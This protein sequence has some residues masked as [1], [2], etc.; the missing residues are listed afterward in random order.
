M[1]RK[2]NWTLKRQLLG[3]RVI[4]SITNC[5]L[6]SGK[7]KNEHAQLHYNCRALGVHRV[8]AHIYMG[9]DINSP[10]QVLHKASCPNRHC[11]NPEHL[12]IGTQSQNIRDT[13][14]ARTHKESRKTSC[15]RGHR[16]IDGNWYWY[17][18]RGFRKRICHECNKIK[19]KEWRDKHNKTGDTENGRHNSDAI[20]W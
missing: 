12:Y 1:G 18:Y 20:T 9:F 13:V 16:Y 2:R 6:W 10:L 19:S 7:T 4:D 15:S 5:W 8:S 14:N 11:F 3:G 17:E